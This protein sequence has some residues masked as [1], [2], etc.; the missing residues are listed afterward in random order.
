MLSSAK[1]KAVQDKIDQEL[2]TYATYKKIKKGK[3]KSGDT[4]NI[5]YVGRIDGTAFEGGSCT[6]DKYP[7]G[8]DLTIGCISSTLF[9]G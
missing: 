2:D 4:V 6:K 5:Y 7:N 8:F 1:K 9:S 3:V